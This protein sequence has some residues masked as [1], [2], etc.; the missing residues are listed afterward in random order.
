MIDRCMKKRPPKKAKKK[1]TY[2]TVDCID[3]R[4]LRLLD[5]TGTPRILLVASSDSSLI[6][7]LGDDGLPRLELS[8]HGDNS[9][10][11]L[12]GPGDVVGCSMAV[13]DH[14]NGIAVNDRDGLSVISCGIYHD[15]DA[16]PIG[17]QPVII[18]TNNESG[19]QWTIPDRADLPTVGN[20]GTQK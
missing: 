6:Q 12:Y 13:T 18:V 1:D 16:T 19:R 5:D 3:A 20:H 14:S 8:V 10:I 7:L 15:R 17:L 9:S 4:L 2:L 11:R